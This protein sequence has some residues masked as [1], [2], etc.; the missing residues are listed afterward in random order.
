MTATDTPAASG[1]ADV[2]AVRVVVADLMRLDADKPLFLAICN[3]IAEEAHETGNVPRRPP[4]MV[5]ALAWFSSKLLA[6]RS[7]LPALDAIGDEMGRLRAEVDEGW[8]DTS[9]EQ[10][11]YRQAAEARLANAEAAGWLALYAIDTVLSS[12]EGQAEHA[13][14]VEAFKA[15]EAALPDRPASPASPP[16]DDAQVGGEARKW[17]P[18]PMI[19]AA[20][21]RARQEGAEE[22]RE[23]A[24]KVSD[25]F[26][27]RWYRDHNGPFDAGVLAASA[28]VASEI[29]KLPLSAQPAPAFLP[30]DDPALAGI[31]AARTPVLLLYPPTRKPHGK[32]LPA[33]WRIDCWGRLPSGTETWGHRAAQWADPVGWLPYP[34]IPEEV[35]SLPTPYTPLGAAAGPEVMADAEAAKEQAALSAQ[36]EEG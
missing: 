9:R 29:R 24:A 22:M 7:A 2:Q 5:S 23:A 17:E 19:A 14:L 26:F 35:A 30:M 31:K 36:P 4:D 6:L 10:F 1:S 28:Y 33:V 12:H 32:F 18:S 16:V 21:A 27:D 3:A 25:A 15:L 20:L 34:S 11:K 8:Y 13:Q